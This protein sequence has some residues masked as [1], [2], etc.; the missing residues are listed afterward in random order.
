MRVFVVGLFLF[1]I[2]WCKKFMYTWRDTE[3]LPLTSRENYPDAFRMTQK[4]IDV[5]PQL[6]TIPPML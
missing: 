5:A 6:P 3:P 4:Y 1:I 2:E